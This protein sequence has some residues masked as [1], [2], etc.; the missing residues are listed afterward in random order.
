[1]VSGL[2]LSCRVAGDAGNAVLVPTPIYPPFLSAPANAAMQLQRSDLTLRDGRWGW[3]WD[4]LAASA[5]AHTRLLML[6]NPHNPV[7]RVFDRAELERLGRFAE[8][9]GLL[10]CSDE[11]HCGLVLDAAATPHIP[12]ATLSPE[13]ARRT[14]TLM[15]PSK[16][17]NIPALYCAFAV[18]SDAALRRRYRQAMRGIV[19]HVNVLGM[20]A[21]E[22]AYRDGEPWRHALI[23][24]LRGNCDRVMAALP[25]MPGLPAVRPAATYLAWIDCRA[26]MAERGIADPAAFFEAAGVGLSDGRPYGAPG[27][28]RLNFGCPR[29]TLDEALARM[30]R[31]LT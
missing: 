22:A 17:W 27:F 18:I 15:A 5:D 19:P 9:R 26:L 21:A 6:C 12:I 1:V 3:D 29:A 2:N 7:G 4:A 24:Y 16:T 13:L 20:V 8:E 31:A 25:Q 23:D 30:A 10:I 14:I 11:I 28:L